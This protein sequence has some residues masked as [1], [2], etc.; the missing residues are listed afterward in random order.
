MSI[1]ISYYNLKNDF[2]T[3]KVLLSPGTTLAE[4][5][6]IMT[7]RSNARIF[8][9]DE[10]AM[11]FYRSSSFPGDLGKVATEPVVLSPS[12]SLSCGL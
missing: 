1:F 4:L 7:N 8:I 6:K 3:Q 12:G 11:T 2:W 10:L 5:C 9:D